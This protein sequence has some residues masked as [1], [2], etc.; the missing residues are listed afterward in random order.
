MDPDEMNNLVNRN[1]PDYFEA[2][3]A[4]MNSKLNALITDEIGDDQAR[5]DISLFEADG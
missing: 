3:L 1:N 2:L 4:A 5:V